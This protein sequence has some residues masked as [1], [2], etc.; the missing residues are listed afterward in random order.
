VQYLGEESPDLQF[1]ERLSALVSSGE[2]SS[3]NEMYRRTELTNLTGPATSVALTRWFTDTGAS[4]PTGSELLFYYTG[5]G[6]GDASG[7]RPPRNTT[8]SLWDKPSMSV[9]QFASL[10]DKMN[11]AVNVMLV[12]VQ[13]HSGGFANVIYTGGEPK[14]GLA[15]QLRFGFFATTAARQAAGCTSDIRG[16]DY[17]EFSTAF[18]AAL[19]G[20]TRTGKVV[21]KP[22]Y[23]HDG[24]TTYM[25]AF[26]YVL[27][28]SDTIDLPMTTS[29]LLLRDFSHFASGRGRRRFADNASTKPVDPSI[30][31]KLLPADATYATIEPYCSPTQRAAITGLG[32]LLG[33]DPVDPVTGARK[34]QI[35]IERDQQKARN[36]MSPLQQRYNQASEKLRHLLLMKYPELGD[37]WLPA[38]AAMRDPS[39][40]PQLRA[41]VDPMPEYAEFVHAADAVGQAF[42]QQEDLERKWVKAQRLI[43]RAETVI[44]KANLPLTASQEIQDRFKLLTE[45]EAGTLTAD[46]L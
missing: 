39:H 5:H 17:R 36:Q 4:L 44:L 25:D 13:C 35:E 43:D 10:L 37:P 30:S 31:Q 19:S 6:G 38:G 23:A 20:K 32:K 15:K 46:H 40:L 11:P 24:K 34:L 9:H 41:E 12:M 27:L 16:E 29:D 42:E 18:F 45:H 2:V 26:T 33:V 7:I 22:S 8:L 3:L 28:T 1:L 21:E 14:N